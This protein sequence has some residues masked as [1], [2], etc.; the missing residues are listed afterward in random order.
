MVARPEV[1]AIIP[2]RGG[3][4]GIPRKN[5]RP[6]AGYP[7]ISYSIAAA[8]QAEQVTRVIVSTDDEEI[9]ATGRQYG[10]ET[11]F[12]RPAEFAQDNTLDLPVFEHAL[13]WLAQ[14][15]GYHPQVVVQLRPTSP[16]RPT[17]LV[18][19]AVRLLLD[20]PEAD[21]VRGVVPAGQNPHKMWRIDPKTGRMKA[22]LQVEGIDEPFNAPRQVLPPV[23]WQT[24]HIDAIR[25]DAILQKHS[26]SGEIV[27]PVYIDSRYTVDIDNPFDW[28]RYEWLVY[29]GGLDM[30]TPGARRRPLPEDVRL[31]VLD[32]DGVLT[33]NRVWVDQDGR[34]AVTASR[35]DSMGIFL[36]KETGVEVIVISTEVNP[37]VEARCKKMK[38]PAVTGTWDKAG[39]LKK[40][41][42]EHNYQSEDVVFL[43]NDV[44]DLPCFSL[45]GCA[46]AVSDAEPEVL[47]HADLIMTR[48]G[49]QG[50]VR[51]LCD[52]ILM[53]KR[54][55]NK[56]DWNG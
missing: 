20:H 44:N 49:G 38:I 10:A 56:G 17:G 21:S 32:F 50:A 29:N 35:G 8:Q 51:E 26:M 18:D 48:S 5:I 34:E 36:L 27:L 11:P 46:A 22:L 19:E 28:V 23:F 31:V 3:S 43:G 55:G 16:V 45:V 53:L 39:V 25:P 40:Y 1:L 15:E 6:F 37:V 7:L 13:D 24:G 9:A 33:D 14:N 52:R 41:M 42:T 47:R 54:A 2:A 4:K 30:V 12:F